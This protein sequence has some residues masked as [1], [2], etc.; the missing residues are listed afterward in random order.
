[1]GAQLVVCFVEVAFDGCVLDRPVHPLD[2]P[3]RPGM[4]RLCQPV[5]DIV[6]GAGIFEGMRSEGLLVGDHLPDFHRRPGVA[7]G[8]GE[9]GSVVGKNRVNPVRDSLDQPAQEICGV[10]SRDRL[11]E[12]DKGEL[13]GP[14]DRDEEIE[15]ALGGS[16]LGDIDMEIADRIGLELPLRERLSPSTSGS[17][18]IPWRCK[19]RC[20]DERVKWG[21]VG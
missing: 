15:L 1:M 3:I 8:I 9:V 10:A 14:V 16:N 19:Q 6:D 18:E 11:A 21:I 2:L 4:L 12:L 17:L 7:S 5:V 20:N 13:R